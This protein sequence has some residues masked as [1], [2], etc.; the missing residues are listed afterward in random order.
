M[1]A[2]AAGLEAERKSAERD[3]GKET[4]AFGVR[5]AADE[6]PSLGASD[7]SESRRSWTLVWQLEL[8]PGEA[9]GVA[10]E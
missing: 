10:L 7:E 2:S 5:V 1:T 6:A 4:A 9:H 3:R 8:H